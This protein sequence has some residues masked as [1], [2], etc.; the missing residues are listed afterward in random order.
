ME[1]NK[2][3]LA[4]TLAILKTTHFNCCPQ[5]EFFNELFMPANMD[6]LYYL[7]PKMHFIHSTYKNTIK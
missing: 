3:H 6:A 7:N 2:K 5:N 4:Q 1:M